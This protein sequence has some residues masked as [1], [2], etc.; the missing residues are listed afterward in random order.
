MGSEFISFPSTLTLP[1]ASRFQ[2]EGFK[3][4]VELG[5]QSGYLDGFN[6]G[7][8]HGIRL[9][10]EVSLIKLKYAYMYIYLH[11]F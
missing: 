8:E 9:G 1:I 7:R 11:V 6:M 5:K 3:Q 2:N 4:G 10:T